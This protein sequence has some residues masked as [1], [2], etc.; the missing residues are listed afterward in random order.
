MSLWMQSAEPADENT[1]V[2]F[3]CRFRLNVRKRIVFR[4]SADER[5]MLFL[6]GE[7][8]GSGPETG[9]AEYWYFQNAEF[10]AGAG[11]HVLT[12]RV[13]MFGRERMS[14]QM[15]VRHGFF[16][17][18]PSGLLRDWDCRIV[19]GC[20]FFPPFPDWGSNPRAEV[21]PEYDP[22]ILKGGGGPWKP[23]VF[24][25]DARELHAPELPPMRYEKTEPQI[26]ARGLE[27]E[28]IRDGSK[29]HPEPPAVP[30]D[31]MR[32]RKDRPAAGTHRADILFFPRYV[33]V[34]DTWH[35]SGQGTVRV[36]FTETPYATERYDNIG[37]KGNK[38]KRDGSCFAGNGDIFHVDGTLDWI[39]YQWRAG[40]YVIVEISGDVKYSCEFYRTGY[41]IP[42]YTGSSPVVRAAY[43]TLCACCHDTFMDC[44]F[45]E[46]LQYIGD[47]RLTAMVLFHVMKDSRLIAKMLRQ[48]LNSQQPDG[49]LYTQ[50]PSKHKQVIPSY[51]PLYLL[52]FHDYWM[53][54]KAD[55]LFREL[56][57][58]ASRLA[59]YLRKCCTADGMRIPGWQFVDWCADWSSDG[60]P[61]GGC[62]LDLICLLAFRA[63]AE[64]LDDPEY[65]KKADS[66]S[67]SILR[68]Y[69]VPDDHL[70][71]DDPA[72][73][74]C[75]EHAQSLAVLAD[76]SEQ[77]RMDAPGMTRCSIY[78]SFYY[79]L[80][81]RKQGR[82]DLIRKRGK[83]WK[84]SLRE[85]LT[86]YPE[87]FRDPRSDCH[88]WGSYILLFDEILEEEKC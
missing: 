28:I 17:D 77:I 42:E 33:C 55:A 79:F 37:L 63:S 5:A 6:D 8:I 61:P 47:T 38:G 25:E 12:A 30:V 29:E 19:S 35:F 53:E 26:Y 45:Y 13:L 56:R 84:E 32:L 41:P 65:E 52:M 40:H 3:R 59:E 60:V 23:V 4:Y 71:Y 83:L 81:C 74:R 9:T 62:V 48:F 34:W 16:V 21:F 15:T 66:L 14:C 7:R 67:E 50:Y 18:D 44:P 82:A 64:M 20:R 57:A 10:D 54:H 11:P 51:M 31:M 72:H 2:V 39:D 46:R 78:F 1:I 87:E 36:I 73:T 49:S 58:G 22:E 27:P 86:T 68:L 76:L 88:G 24:R 80:A 85:G 69:Y 43:D 75:S 70:F